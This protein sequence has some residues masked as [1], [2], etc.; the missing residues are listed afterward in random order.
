MGL[1]LEQIQS[2]NVFATA[3]TVSWKKIT[4]SYTDLAMASLTKGEFQDSEQLESLS[5]TTSIRL[6]AIA[7]GVLMTL[8]DLTQGSV[9]IYLLT[10]VLP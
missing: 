1:S 6:S 2:A 8:N 3:A 4:K 5:G 9:D 10:S 7:V